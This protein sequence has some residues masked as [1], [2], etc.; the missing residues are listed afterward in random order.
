M[1][2][3]FSPS[4]PPCKPVP[5]RQS[6]TS[7]YPSTFGNAVKI[8]PP[9]A[10]HLSLFATQSF[11]SFSAKHTVVTTRPRPFKIRAHTKPSPP[12]LP[13]PHTQSIF[14]V[15]AS[16]SASSA[17]AIPARSISANDGTPSFSIVYPSASRICLF[18][19]TYIR[20][21]FLQP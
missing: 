9:H 3:A 13:P 6:T 7:A 15:G 21:S 12:L 14:P 4:T 5:N 8:S 1:N 19:S 18:V 11:E 17:N 2:F 10:V 16:L 20:R